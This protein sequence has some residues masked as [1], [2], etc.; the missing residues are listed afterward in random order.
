MRVESNSLP[1]QA[2]RTYHWRIERRG[3]LLRWSIDG[4]PFLEFDDPYPLEGKGHDRLG[5]SG[6][7]SE[8]YF[9]NL[10]VL[11]LDGSVPTAEA[12]PVPAEP[13]APPAGPFADNFDRATLGDDWDVTNPSAA[14]LENGALTVELMHN[15]PVWLKRPMPHQ[16]HHRVRRLDR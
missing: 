8:I 9:D 13:P 11:P 14:R 16:R 5:L 6:F 2:G 1:V 12:P 7:E 15:R 10:R 4:R 3:P